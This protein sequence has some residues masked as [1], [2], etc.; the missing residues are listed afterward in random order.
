MT[1]LNDAIQFLTIN[2]E[3]KLGGGFSD[4]GVTYGDLA[5]ELKAMRDAR[6]EYIEFLKWLEEEVSYCI[7]NKEF[8]KKNILEVVRKKVKN[9]FEE[10]FFKKSA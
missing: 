3:I 8:K 1:K 2:D 5:K 10:K 9:S 6:R 4:A 7:K